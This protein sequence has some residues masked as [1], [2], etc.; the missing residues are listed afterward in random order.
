MVLRISVSVPCALLINTHLCII[1]LLIR[2]IIHVLMNPR[3]NTPNTTLVSLVYYVYHLP[4]YVLIM[5]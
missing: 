5:S 2:S 3:A 4:K 1:E